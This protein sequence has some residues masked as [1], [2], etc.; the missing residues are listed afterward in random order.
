M[1]LQAFLKLT[2]YSTPTPTTTTTSHHKFRFAFTS[3]AAGCTTTGTRT[4][5]TKRQKRLLTIQDWAL[6]AGSLNLT[7]LQTDLLQDFRQVVDVFMFLFLSL[8]GWSATA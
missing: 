8:E 4:N 1:Q 6:S 3:A 5:Q 7:K 2:L